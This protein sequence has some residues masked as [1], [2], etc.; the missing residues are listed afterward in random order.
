[1]DVRYVFDVEGPE[2]ASSVIERSRTLPVVV[3]FWAGWCGPCRTLGPML[4][5]SVTRRA[6]EVLLAKVDVDRNQPLAQQYGVQ[7]IPAVHAFRDGQVVD[8]FTGAV[9]Q[10]QI[11]AF[12]DR[13]VPTATDR[14]LELAASQEPEDARRTLELAHAQDPGDGRVAIALAELLV[15]D[16]PERAAGLAAAH[17]HAPDAARVTAALAVASAST[18]DIAGLRSRAAAG[19]PLATVDL[20]RALLAQ[21]EIDEALGTALGALETT[22]PSDPG[23]EPLRAGIIDLLTLLGDDPRVAP[24]RARMARA[25]F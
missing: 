13:L 16:D 12:L 6:G 1:M 22:D 8:R 7:G 20:A 19:D 25:L 21:G 10:A 18:Q 14:A 24:A 5:A 9:P 17:P 3:D 4:E 15:D 11:E 2:F 23:R